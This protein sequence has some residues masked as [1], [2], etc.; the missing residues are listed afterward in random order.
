MIRLPSLLVLARY[1]TSAH[2]SNN[3]EQ[4]HDI[5]GSIQQFFFPIEVNGETGGRGLEAILICAMFY[6][7]SPV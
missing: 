5:K 7:I 3:T 2:K 6:L 1:I 4:L